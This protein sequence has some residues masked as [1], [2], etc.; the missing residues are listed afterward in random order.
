MEPTEQQSPSDPRKARIERNQQ[1]MVA[2]YNASLVSL[3]TVEHLISKRAEELNLLGQRIE[4][5]QLRMMITIL[6]AHF[7]T[8]PRDTVT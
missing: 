5:D 8:D 6:R 4:S 7:S 3:D 2:R 1:Q